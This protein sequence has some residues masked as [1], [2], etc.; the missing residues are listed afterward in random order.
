MLIFTLSSILCVQ[1]IL[2]HWISFEENPSVY[3]ADRYLL[4]LKHFKNIEQRRGKTSKLSPF[5]K[6]RKH[7]EHF[8]SVSF[9]SFS[10]CVCVCVSPVNHVFVLESKIEI[11]L[12]V[13][14]S[15]FFFSIHVTLNY[16]HCFHDV[17]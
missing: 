7:Y 6:Q 12:N 11:M 5:T 2:L 10:P 14:I 15:C 3:S 4:I 13:L 1:N 16:D 9:L 8:D 17:L